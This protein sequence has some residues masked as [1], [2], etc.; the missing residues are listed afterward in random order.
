MAREQDLLSPEIVNRG[1]ENS[2]PYAGSLSFSVRVRRNLPNF[3]SSVNLKYVR[4]GYGSLLSHGA[5]LL[6]APVLMVLFSAEIGKLTFNDVCPKFDFTDALFLVGLLGLLLYVYL[7]LTPRST[8]LVDFACYLPPKDLKVTF[9]SFLFIQSWCE[10]DLN[11]YVTSFPFHAICFVDF[12]E[13]IHRAS[14]KIRQLQ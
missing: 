7:D 1:V 5:Y 10:Q 2:G 13:R 14:K 4:L 11:L 8:Y 3:L 12:K 6:A 9:S